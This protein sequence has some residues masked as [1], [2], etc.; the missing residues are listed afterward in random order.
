MYSHVMYVSI[1]VA[2]TRR[3]KLIQYNDR[4]INQRQRSAPRVVWQRVPTDEFG[5]WYPD[6]V[7]PNWPGLPQFFV[8]LHYKEVVRWGAF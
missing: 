1:C 6:W 5:P 3:I 7:Q 2:W 4:S 8:L